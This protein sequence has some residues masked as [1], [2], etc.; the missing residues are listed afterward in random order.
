MLW[1]GL[2]GTEVRC[3]F[4]LLVRFFF[5]FFFVVLRFERRAYTLSHST[6]LFID[7]FFF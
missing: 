5:F 6:A 7:G 2:I 3:L 1:R 4:G